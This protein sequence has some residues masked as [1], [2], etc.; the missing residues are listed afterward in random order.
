MEMAFGLRE[1]AVAIEDQR[2]HPPIIVMTGH[3][4]P[5]ARR[6]EVSIVGRFSPAATSPTGA[7]RVSARCSAETEPARGPSP[8]CRR[9]HP[10]GLLDQRVL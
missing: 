5:F 3:T 6:L 8:P 9:R 4:R 10:A 1:D 7:L 2:S